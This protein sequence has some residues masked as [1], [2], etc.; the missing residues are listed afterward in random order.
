[1]KKKITVISMVIVLMFTMLLFMGSHCISID[2]CFVCRSTP[3]IC[4][5]CPKCDEYHCECEEYDISYVITEYEFE[6]N[7]FGEFKWNGADVYYRVYID[8][9]DENGFVFI[10]KFLGQS[11]ISVEAVNATQGKNTVR[12]VSDIPIQHETYGKVIST[13]YWT[14][15]FSPA[16]VIERD[17][18]VSFNEWFNRYELIWGETSNRFY[19][20]YLDNHEGEGF[21]FILGRTFRIHEGEQGWLSFAEFEHRMTA[22]KNTIRMIVMHSNWW[23]AGSYTYQNG[24]LRHEAYVSYWTIDF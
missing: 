7:I 14:F 18:A 10:D 21:W 5:I 22:G 19:S 3:C 9:H 12:V 2:P 13:G 15:E 16:E 4:E 24:M 20:F 11:D 17:W 1:M 6:V 23:E 8:R